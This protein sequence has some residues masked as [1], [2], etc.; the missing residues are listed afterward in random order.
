[1]YHARNSLILLRSFEIDRIF[2]NRSNSQEVAKLLV[3]VVVAEEVPR[4]FCNRENFKIHHPLAL[5]YSRIND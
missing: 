1:M 3:G 5:S 2:L 4:L